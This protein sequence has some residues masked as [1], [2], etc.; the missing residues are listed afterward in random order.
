MRIIA[1]VITVAWILCGKMVGVVPAMFVG[2]S[3]RI[4]AFCVVFMVYSKWPL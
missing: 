3:P 4:K 2:I 1:L